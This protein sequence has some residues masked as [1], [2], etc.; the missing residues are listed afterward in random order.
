MPV[1]LFPQSEQDCGPRLLVRAPA[2]TAVVSIPLILLV[3]A[4][5]PRRV[6]N[7]PKVVLKCAVSVGGVEGA[8]NVA[9]QS[10]R[11][12]AG[13]VIVVA[14]VIARWILTLARSCSEHKDETDDEYGKTTGFHGF[15]QIDSFLL[16]GVL[17][18]FT[19]S[20]G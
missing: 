9:H 19:N 18:S 1:L 12:S 20:R 15:L 11:T 14:A 5:A 17:S 6:E 7:A 3:S 16:S 10:A 4:L 13:V 2:P 8:S